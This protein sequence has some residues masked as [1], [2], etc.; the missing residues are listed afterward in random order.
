MAL[1]RLEGMM[2]SGKVVAVA[3]LMIATMACDALAADR[4][5][6]AEK[7]TATW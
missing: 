2:R 6:L 4:V 7:F 1:N 3:V 5:V